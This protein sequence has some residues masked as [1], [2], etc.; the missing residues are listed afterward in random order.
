MVDS[1]LRLYRSSAGLGSDWLIEGPSPVHGLVIAVADDPLASVA[2]STEMADLLGVE[3]AVLDHGG[4]F[5]P[6]EAP[7]EAAAAISAFWMSLG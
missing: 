3:T 4:H 7:V 5:W 2:V 6:V 1:I